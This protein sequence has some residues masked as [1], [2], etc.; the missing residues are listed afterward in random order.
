MTSCYTQIYLSPLSELLATVDGDNLPE[1]RLRPQPHGTGRVVL[2]THALGSPYVAS[3]V[4]HRPRTV[5]I[6]ER[7]PVVVVGL[8][9]RCAFPRAISHTTAVR[10]VTPPASGSGKQVLHSDGHDLCAWWY[11]NDHV[12]TSLGSH[13]LAGL[14]HAVSVHPDVI[15]STCDKLDFCSKSR[16]V[17][18]YMIESGL[19]V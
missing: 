10:E 8:S 9:L 11:W 4:G 18:I 16:P 7:A 14:I 13:R 6:V 15:I 1:C 5:V 2:G 3:H 19:A 17:Y 12:R